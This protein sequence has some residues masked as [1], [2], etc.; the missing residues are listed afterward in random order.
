MDIVENFL[1]FVGAEEKFYLTEYRVVCH[2]RKLL[3]FCYKK[4]RDFL[5]IFIELSE[6]GGRLKRLPFPRTVPDD[7]GRSHLKDHLEN[8]SPRK[9]G[10]PGDFTLLKKFPAT[11]QSGMGLKRIEGVLPETLEIVLRRKIYPPTLF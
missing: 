4:G 10:I 9:T 2:K 5:G 3:I 8:L 11:G 7:H 1:Q 6:R